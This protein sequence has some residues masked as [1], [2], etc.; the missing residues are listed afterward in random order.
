MKITLE[1][2][3]IIEAIRLQQGLDP[4]QQ[5]QLKAFRPRGLGKAQFSAEITD[6]AADVQGDGDPGS[7]ARQG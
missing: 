2:S 5:V 6:G 4:S 3:E 7:Q 1:E